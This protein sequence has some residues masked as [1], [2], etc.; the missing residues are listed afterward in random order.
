M[1]EEEETATLEEMQVNLASYKEQLAQA[2][3]QPTMPSGTAEVLLQQVFFLVANLLLT[4]NEVGGLC[5][6][7]QR[8][9]NDY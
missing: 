7:A 5:I 9:D 4:L 1:A 6:C 3:V 8:S 2:R